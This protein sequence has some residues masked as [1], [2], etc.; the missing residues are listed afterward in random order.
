MVRIRIPLKKKEKELAVRMAN[1]FYN[2]A[3]PLISGILFGIFTMSKHPFIGAF[4][5][6][7]AAIPFYS[8]VYFE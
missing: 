4:C 1:Y 3:V 7:L 2:S 6:I 5:L 8:E